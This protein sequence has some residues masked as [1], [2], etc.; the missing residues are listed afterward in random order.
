MSHFLP[1]LWRKLTNDILTV[2]RPAPTASAQI[3]PVSQGLKNNLASQELF[4]F[5]LNCQTQ[6]LIAVQFSVW[7][8][9][10]VGRLLASEFDS[11]RSMC[12]ELIGQ[13]LCYFVFQWPDIESISNQV[14]GSRL[15][16]ISCT[17]QRVT[18]NI[19]LWR[20]QCGHGV[21]K[22]DMCLKA[23]KKYFGC[24]S[25]GYK[26][27]FLNPSILLLWPDNIDPQMTVTNVSVKSI[28]MYLNDQYTS[29]L[30]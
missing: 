11:N 25:A 19:W 16:W 4:Y 5:P 1:F 29:L 6:K 21:F 28:C 2:S 12:K 24:S 18:Q 30:D 14:L 7:E 23:A 9:Q 3:E 17:Y 15:Q 10:R 26:T 27:F 20:A 8:I 22:R 13:S